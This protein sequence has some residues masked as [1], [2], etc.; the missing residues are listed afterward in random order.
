MEVLTSS[1]YTGFIE[2]NMATTALGDSP[3][4]G[5]RNPGIQLSTKGSNWTA[6]AGLFGTKQQSVVSEVEVEFD[7]PAVFTPGE[8]I[9]A[10]G[11]GGDDTDPPRDL[12][13]GWAITGRVTYSPWH[14]KARA[15]H[16]GAGFSYRNLAHGTRFRVRER[17]E[18][19]IG[20]RTLN[21]GRFAS[22]DFLR[23]NAEAAWVEG[24]FSLKGEYLGMLVNTDTA[25][26]DPTFH[27][28]SVEGN[29]F[30]TGESKNYKFSSGVF[31][32]IMPKGVVGKGGIGA[33]E[34]GARY[35]QLDLTDG[36][37]IGGEQENLTFGVNWY[38]NSNMRFMAN[39]VHVLDIDGGPFGGANPSA[40]TLRSQVHW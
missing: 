21:T 1:K 14:E 12:D 28:F 37:I 5:G 31:D 24:P 29:W 4:F 15:L 7:Q 16:L 40:F 11:D 35:T 33:W 20:S 27:G 19:H 39:Y 22:D 9:T 36:P 25:S 18:V 30:L 38:V 17:P 2:R 34:V 23:W 10:T 8:T 26:G 13:D 6:A 3:T 32:A